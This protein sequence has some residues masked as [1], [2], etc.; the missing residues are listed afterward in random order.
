MYLLPVATCRWMTLNVPSL[1]SPTSNRSTS[2]IVLQYR[3]QYIVQL[4]AQLVHRVVPDYT[5]TDC[6]RCP[7]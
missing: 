3:L 1:S 6:D 7:Q 4:R 5:E 2:H